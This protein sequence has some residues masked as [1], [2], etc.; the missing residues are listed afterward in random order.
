[1]RYKQKPARS[2]DYLRWV[3]EHGGRCCVC[4]GKFEQAH[5]FGDKG[6]GQKCSDF[7]VCRICEK[8]HTTYQGKRFIGFERAGQLDVLCAMQ[9]DALQMLSD[10]AEALEKTCKVKLEEDECF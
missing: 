8:C 10:Y 9:R 7:M 6:M 4:G 5:H 1:M 2:K 3:H